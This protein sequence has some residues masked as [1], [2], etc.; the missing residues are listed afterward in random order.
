MEVADVQL[1]EHPVVAQLHNKVRGGEG[2]RRIAAG[3]LWVVC[4]QE[5]VSACV[6][7]HM[8]SLCKMI[9]T[10]KLYLSKDTSRR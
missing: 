6:D 3:C 1:E 9:N 10:Y 8:R 4:V 5:R 7:T 2:A